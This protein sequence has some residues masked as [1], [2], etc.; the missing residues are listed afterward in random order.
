MKYGPTNQGESA[1]L[2]LEMVRGHPAKQITA[3]VYR[4]CGGYGWAQDYIRRSFT[5]VTCTEV[6]A[7]QPCVIVVKKRDKLAASN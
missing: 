6:T 7:L 2:N 3:I 5:G 1:V 4:K